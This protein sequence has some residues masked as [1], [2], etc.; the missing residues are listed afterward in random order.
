VTKV[1]LARH[2]ESDWNAENRFQGHTDRPLTELGRH[3][4]EL[5]A[6]E[7]A[8]LRLAAVYTSPLRRCTATAEIVAAPLGLRPTLDPALCEVDVGSWAGLTRAE[9]EQRFPEGFRSWIAGGN[10]WEDGETY[11]QMSARVLEALHAIAAGHPEEQVLVVSHGGP[12]R[13][14]HA[15]ADGLGVQEYRRLR[16]VEPNASLSAVAV[17]NGRIA[18]LD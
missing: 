12:I 17:E 5:L 3:Q 6:E 11:A 10:G 18:R 9:V 7:V 15:A 2:G 4:A 16:P 14:I 8:Q 1:Y 13:A